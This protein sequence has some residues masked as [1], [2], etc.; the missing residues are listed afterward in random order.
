M[1][2]NR[3]AA[4]SGRA[5]RESA[6]AGMVRL[7]EPTTLPSTFRVCVCIWHCRPCDG[8]RVAVCESVATAGRCGS[9]QQ[10]YGGQSQEQKESD[11][12]GYGG[13]E[14]TRGNGGVCTYLAQQ[15]RNQSAYAPRN[16][17]VQSRSNPYHHA[18]IEPPEPQPHRK[19][20]N[21]RE[22]YVIAYCRRGSSCPKTGGRKTG[23]RLCRAGRDE[24][25]PMLEW[26]GFASRLPSHRLSVFACAYGTAIWPCRWFSGRGLRIGRH[27]WALRESTA[28]IWRPVPGTEGIRPCRLRRTRIH[29]RQWRGLHL[30][31]AAAEE[32]ECLRSPQP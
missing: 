16:H 25:V 3:R 6:Y 20:A 13:H 10:K 28:E 7:C 11:H 12:V 21:R 26:S 1:P 27:S 4:L 17:E 19:T 9:L 32:P 30:P 2:K 24:R 22:Q 31:C 5:R 18:Q 29:Q 23:G 8:F 14:Y 15:Q